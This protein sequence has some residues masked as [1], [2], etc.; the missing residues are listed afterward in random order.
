[1]IYQI[2]ELHTF[3]LIKEVETEEEAK[4]YKKD[5]WERKRRGEIINGVYY[6]EKKDL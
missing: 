5:I 2:W 3:K 6:I 4:E 1:M